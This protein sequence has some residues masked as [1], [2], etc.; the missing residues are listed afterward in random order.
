MM[1]LLVVVGVLVLLGVVYYITKDSDGDGELTTEEVKENATELAAEVKEKATEIA[2]DV[3]DKL[4]LNDDGKVNL[5]DAILAAQTVK[6]AA[7]S[8][9]TTAKRNFTRA[10]NK[11]AKAKA[12]K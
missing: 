3:K 12:A 2:A 10:K 1:T 6:A 9:K 4:D 5:E 11:K 7:K 8:A